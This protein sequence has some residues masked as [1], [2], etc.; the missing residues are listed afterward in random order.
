MGLMPS[1]GTVP[2]HNKGN[3]HT[4]VYGDCSASYAVWDGNSASNGK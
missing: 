4:G 2:P 3:I 1:L